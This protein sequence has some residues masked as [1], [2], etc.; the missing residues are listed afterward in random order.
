MQR[1]IHMQTTLMDYEIDTRAKGLH[2][3]WPSLDESGFLA[4]AFRDA[5]TQSAAFELLRRYETAFER[6]I[7]RH[8]KLL[9]NLQD[10]HKNAFLRNEP[11]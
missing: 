1:A 8:I 5:T 7:S 9:E 2:E 11:E 4:V 10:R 3:Q 6:S